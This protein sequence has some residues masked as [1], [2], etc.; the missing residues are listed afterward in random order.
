M[1]MP[2]RIPIKDY[3]AELKIT[4]Q[5]HVLVE[6]KTDKITI[7][8]LLLYYFEKKGEK[9]SDKTIVV[10]S[11]ERIQ[12]PNI[13]SNR[14]KIVEVFKRVSSTA[15]EDKIVGFV[16]RE[17]HDFSWTN[18][19]EDHLNGHRVS[20]RLIWSRGH[21]IENYFFD[22]II[23]RESIFSLSTIDH[24]DALS[25]F[26]NSLD[27][28]LRVACAIT[29]S[30]IELGSSTSL[31]NVF[32]RI[33]RSIYTDTIVLFPNK[34]EINKAII[35][36]K[37]TQLLGDNIIARNFLVDLDNKIIATRAA[38][39][40]DTI[41][42]LCHGHIGMKVISSLY[43]VCVAQFCSGVTDDQKDILNT[44]HDLKLAI[45]ASFWAKYAL[46]SNVI[47]PSELFSY[48]DI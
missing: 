22:P 38:P 46:S 40:L 42:W 32:E 19:I 11:A 28:A 16:D 12:E 31:R 13:L 25:A 17:F 34:I 41:R 10:D 23:L 45:V 43:S 8:K 21:S 29:L 5:K 20:G 2:L 1:P 44:S 9:L 18:G 14:E 7:G 37:L 35:E 24:S 6:G 33:G 30:S 26:E 27:D 47:Y 36:P 15:D 39:A 4:K 3:L 48:I